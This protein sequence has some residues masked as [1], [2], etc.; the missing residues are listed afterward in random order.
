VELAWVI[1]DLVLPRP[2]LSGLYH[3]AADPISKYDLLMLVAEIYGKK[4]EII[5]DEEV[6]IDRSHN[7]DRFHSVTGYTAPSWPELVRRM[8]EFK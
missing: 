7:A 4:I 3:V 5:P 6:V 1:R 8:Y 2:E